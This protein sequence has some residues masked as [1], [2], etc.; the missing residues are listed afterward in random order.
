MTNECCKILLICRVDQGHKQHVPQYITVKA[1]QPIILTNIQCMMLNEELSLKTI[2]VLHMKEDDFQV[3]E[4]ILTRDQRT[5]K[6]IYVL[7][8]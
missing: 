1:D 2:Y 8:T 4:K 7:S 5:L 3:K 6:T